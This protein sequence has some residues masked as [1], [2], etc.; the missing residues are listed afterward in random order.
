LPKLYLPIH[1]NQT[2]TVIVDP[3]PVAANQ[4]GVHIDSAHKGSGGEDEVAAQV[5]LAKLVVTPAAVGEYLHPVHA[6]TNVGA[7]EETDNHQ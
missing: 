4:I 2:A 7:G 6:H 1:G 5:E 3:L